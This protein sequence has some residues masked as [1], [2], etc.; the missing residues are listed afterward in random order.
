[1]SQQINQMNYAYVRWKIRKPNKHVCSQSC[2]KSGPPICV[3]MRWDS[4]LPPNEYHEVSWKGSLDQSIMARRF[5][6]DLRVYDRT[7]FR[8][9]VHGRVGELVKRSNVNTKVQ[10]LSP[11][12]GGHSQRH[13]CY[14]HLPWPLWIVCS[15]LLVYMEGKMW[16]SDM[17][18]SLNIDGLLW[19]EG[20]WIYVTPNC[21]HPP[22]PLWDLWDCAIL[23]LHTLVP[24]Q[25]RETCLESIS[26]SS[27]PFN[28]WLLEIILLV[29]FNNRMRRYLATLNKALKFG[30]FS[31]RLIGKC[32]MATGLL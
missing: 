25:K 30:M 23:P 4:Y 31:A 10:L 22:Q 27:Y 1:M 17:L 21:Q 32:A 2:S 15:W 13:I 18:A 29:N 9:C 24:Y 14:S 8:R 11:A 5:A 26:L 20:P 6:T 19:W 3:R 28:N 12:D 16:C 7:P